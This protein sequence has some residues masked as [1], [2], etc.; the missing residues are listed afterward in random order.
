[1]IPAI[2]IKELYYSYR[3]N[4]GLK[5]IEALKGISLEVHQGESFGFLGHN[6][7]GKT[8][9]IKCILG[10][11]RPSSGTIKI[12]G[13]SDTDSRI[14]VGYLPEQPYFYDHLTVNELVTFYGCL[15]G[16]NSKSLHSAVQDA[17]ERVRISNRG[18]S[19]MRSLSK[20]LTQR[21]GM[22]QAIVANPRLLIL[23]EPFSGLDPIGR[24][25]FRDL[26]S[27]LKKTGTTIFISS[28]VLGDIE[29]LC[30]RVSIMA[31]GEIKEVI[32]L[33]D[34]KSQEQDS[35]V[36]KIAEDQVKCTELN[37]PQVTTTRSS[38]GILHLTFN[39]EA[40]AIK[41]LEIAISKGLSI[42]GFHRAHSSLEDLFIRLV[43]FDESTGG[44][45]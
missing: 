27:D 22:A 18:D 9:T 37:I 26:L 35:F 20:G 39:S 10:L 28:H 19:P 34:L 12:F 25:E 36:L 17:L 40:S 32:A 23:D 31:H 6:G 3:G 30:D 21:V 24:R 14:S 44:A 42:E 8:T 13:N 1:M 11:I 45:A 4:W 43:N 29:F 38:N 33:K 15:A 2:D 41:G 5:K 7:A 16:V